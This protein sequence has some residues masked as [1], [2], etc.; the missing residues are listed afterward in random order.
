LGRF[1]TAQGPAPAPE[2]GETWS[3]ESHA[4]CAGRS[5]LQALPR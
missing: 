1:L 5:R 3:F 4:G 2:K